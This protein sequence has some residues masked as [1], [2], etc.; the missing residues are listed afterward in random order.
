MSFSLMPVRLFAEERGGTWRS[1]FTKQETD[2][3]LEDGR[4]MDQMEAWEINPAY[5]A[6][7]DFNLSTRNMRLVM[8]ELGFDV[9]DDGALIEI[10]QFQR[11]S[12]RWLTRHLGERSAAVDAETHCDMRWLEVGLREGYLSDRIEK[13]AYIVREGRKRSATHVMV[14]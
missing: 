9:T 14:V 13:A 2:Y 11:A 5:R 12:A 4:S 8:G 1:V 10:G 6:D 7:L 3:F